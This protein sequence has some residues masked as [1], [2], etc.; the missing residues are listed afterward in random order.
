MSTEGTIPKFVV[1]REKILTVTADATFLRET[2]VRISLNLHSVV[3]A[4][5]YPSVFS[6]SGA[7]AGD[8]AEDEKAAE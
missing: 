7:D 1:C 8:L 3:Y 5:Y 2:P 6:T 4:D